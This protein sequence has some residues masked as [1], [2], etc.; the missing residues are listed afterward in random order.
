MIAVVSTLNVLGD[1]VAAVQGAPLLASLARPLA[2]TLLPLL[3]LLLVL[4]VR[5]A[6]MLELV[7]VAGTVGAAIMRLTMLTF[8]PEMIE[9]WPA[10]MA[11]VLFVIYLYIP[12]R[13]MVSLAMAVTFSVAAPLWWWQMQHPAVSYDEILRGIT[14]LVLTNALCFHRGQLAAAQPA[15]A[16]RPAARARR[17]AVDR[18]AHRHRQPP[19]PGRRARA[20][21]APLRAGGRAALTADDRC[22]PLQGL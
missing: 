17:A 12:V 7:M 19:P 22:R 2:A 5:T 18:R 4:R 1:L 10:W 13:L 9:L 16:I 15:R 6:F 14:W 3:V 8:H 21:M 11:A 20:R